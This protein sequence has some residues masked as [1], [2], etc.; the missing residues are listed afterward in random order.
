MI[1]CKFEVTDITVVYLEFIPCGVLGVLGYSSY[2][3]LLHVSEGHDLYLVIFLGFLSNQPCSG[4]APAEARCGNADNNRDSTTGDP[5]TICWYIF[6]FR[7]TIQSRGYHEFKNSCS[8]MVRQF[9][10]TCFIPCTIFVA[11]SV[12]GSCLIVKIVG[13]WEAAVFAGY[14]W[15]DL[16]VMGIGGFAVSMVQHSF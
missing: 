2:K 8:S 15:S 7:C 13:N 1:G 5:S 16:A 11:S 9:V 3:V 6:T 14:N 12:F 10:S 4:K